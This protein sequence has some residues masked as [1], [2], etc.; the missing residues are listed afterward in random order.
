MAGSTARTEDLAEE[1]PVALVCNGISYAVMMCSPGDIEDFALG[2]ALSEGLLQNPGQ[3]YGIDVQLGEQG[4]EVQMEVAAS[5]AAALR[6]RRRALAGRTGCGLCGVESLQQWQRP[7][8]KVQHRSP[9]HLRPAQVER[10]LRALPQQ[11]QLQQRTGAA[12]AAAWVSIAGDI[13]CVRED[14][15][16]HNALDK[17]IG[18]L[19]R[20]HTPTEHQMTHCFEDGFILLTSRASYEMVQKAVMMGA[21]AVCAVSAAT[22]LAVATAKEYDLALAG[23]ARAGSLLVYHGR[24]LFSPNE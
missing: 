18:A 17:L 5:I 1:V 13:H 4:I 3:C 8:K 22:A 16:R 19:A 9:M 24:H 12:H 20:S 2:F 14:I 11:Q 6:E 23:F 21:R 10:A 7:L 15:G